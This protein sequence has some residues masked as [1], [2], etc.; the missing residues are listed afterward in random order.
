MEEVE[1]RDRLMSMVGV[2]EI[3]DPAEIVRDSRWLEDVVLV[4]SIASDVKLEEAN[5]VTNESLL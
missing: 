5:V 2:L 4:R 3:S 1:E